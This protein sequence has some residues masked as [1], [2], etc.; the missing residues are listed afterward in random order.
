MSK[1]R[2]RIREEEISL[3]LELVDKAIAEEQDT[4]RLVSLL[5]LE[6]HFSNMRKVGPTPYKHVPYRLYRK[7]RELYERL[8]QE[9]VFVSAY[10][11]V[12]EDLYEKS[13]QKE[14]DRRERQRRSFE[15]A[16]RQQVKRLT[17]QYGISKEDLRAKGILVPSG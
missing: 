5:E 1:S 15:K 3:V 2:P 11:W 10:P 12:K 16:K 4:A 7:R 8:K 14:H 9:Q 13:D 6:S 17:R